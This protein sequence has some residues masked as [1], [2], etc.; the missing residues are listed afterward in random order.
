MW[1]ID[2][3]KSC[4]EWVVHLTNSDTNEDIYGKWDGCIELYTKDQQLHVCE[5]ARHIQSLLEIRELLNKHFSEL[6]GEWEGYGELNDP[7][8][9]E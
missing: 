1:E 9:C 8:L 4:D 7:V 3:T 6:R 2:K 5:I